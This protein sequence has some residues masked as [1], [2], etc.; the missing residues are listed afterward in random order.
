M[1]SGDEHRAKAVASLFGPRA[2]AFLDL[3]GTNE[4]H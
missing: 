1:R 2:F 3:G 4:Y